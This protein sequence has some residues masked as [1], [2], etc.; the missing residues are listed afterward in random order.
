MVK[1]EGRFGA[2]VVRKGGVERGRIEKSVF[3]FFLARSE[4]ARSDTRERRW[5]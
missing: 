2:R 5:S 3:F 1:K 4:R